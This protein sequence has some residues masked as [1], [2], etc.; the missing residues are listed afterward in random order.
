VDSQRGSDVEQSTRTYVPNVVGHVAG[1]TGN[2]GNTGNLG[3]TN[4]A[5]NVPED[6]GGFSTGVAVGVGGVLVAAG[7]MGA[8]ILI[9]R[10][11]RNS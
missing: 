6:A 4:T 1:N 11:G 9:G 3:T 8:G 7:L 5:D 2:T 10:R